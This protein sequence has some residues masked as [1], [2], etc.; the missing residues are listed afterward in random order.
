MEEYY[1]LFGLAFVWT[2]FAVVQDLKTQEVSNWLN[3]S[4]IAV[5]LAYRSFYAS[6]FSNLRFFLLGL[7]GFGIFFVFAWVFYYS[8]VFAGGD[9]K[10][11]MGYGVILP[12]T[13]YWSLLYLGLGFV[14]VLFF[15]GAIY[16]LCYSFFISLRD[17]GR[18]SKEFRK[19]LHKLKWLFVVAV[20]LAVLFFFLIEFLLWIALVLFLIGGLVLYAYLRAVDKLM[21]RLKRWDELQEGDWLER[22]VRIGRLVIKKSVHGLSLAE[23]KKIKRARKKVLIKEGI[24]F[25]PS[26][27]GA[28]GI[29]VYAYLTS[30]SFAFLEFLF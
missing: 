12:Y 8:R 2:I 22:D 20:V 27:L 6:A 17:W 23:I 1:F 26:F 30:G 24:P 16:G 4:F 21:V 14:F 28:L 3:F 19:N 15:V 29:M 10:L 25:T 11:L 18:F 5:A 7:A 9:A 13:S